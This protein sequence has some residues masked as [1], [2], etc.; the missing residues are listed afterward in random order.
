[1]S[2]SVAV[3]TGAEIPLTPPTTRGGGMKNTSWC[4][5]IRPAAGGWE[6]FWFW[7][8]S[9]VGNIFWSSLC[10]SLGTSHKRSSRVIRWMSLVGSGLDGHSA[11]AACVCLASICSN[12]ACLVLLRVPTPGAIFYGLLYS[13]SARRRNRWRDFFCYRLIT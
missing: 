2:P 6:K 12:S 1:M 13:V 5:V 8:S 7:F 9:R 10:A 11:H 4:W 3:L